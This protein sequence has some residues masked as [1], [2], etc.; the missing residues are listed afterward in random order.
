M[1]GF[2]DLLQSAGYVRD[3]AAV[4]PIPDLE[5]PAPDDLDR[6]YD[7][8]AEEARVESDALVLEFMPL[9]SVQGS[10]ASVHVVVWYDGDLTPG[11]RRRLARV[12]RRRF[13]ASQAAPAV[14]RKS[15]SRRGDGSKRIAPTGS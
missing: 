11:E 1:G 5:P 6:L 7:E 9:P 4:G 12:L 15:P 10:R 8:I 14:R 3:E 2:E 13:G